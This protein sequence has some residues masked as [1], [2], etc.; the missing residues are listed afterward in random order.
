LKVNLTSYGLPKCDGSESDDSFAV[1]AWDETVIAVLA[2]GAGAARDAREA[3]RRIVQS[4][5]TNYSARPTSWS[6]QKALTEFTRIINHTLHQ[7]SL[8]RYAAP[9][10]ISTLSIAIIEGNRLFGLNV[11]DSRVYLSR[12][13][14]LSQLSHDHV[15][16]DRTFSHV[17]QRAIGL[18]PEVEPHSFET[19]LRDGD[20]AFLCSDGVS[21]VLPDD[22][23][24]RRLTHRPAARAIVQHARM[25]ATDETL[26]DM[27][28]IVIDVAETGKLR[29][30][31]QLPLPIPET[32]RR[33]E[34]ID[35][36]ELVRPFQHSDRV[37]LATKDDAHWSLKF[38]PLEARDNE[39]V[40][41]AF[42]KEQWNATRLEAPFFVKAFVPEH[43]T[44]RY[45]VMEFV[46]APSLKMLLKSRRLSVDEAI[47]LGKFLLEAST[48]LL[49]HDLVH[50]DI[51]PENI[52]VVSDYDHL[53]F[54]LVDLGSAA[55]VFS[56]ISRAGTAT[57]LA[58]ERFHGEP[59]CERT[60][61]F[62]IGVTLFH[63]L[64][65]AFPYGEIERFQT[66]QFGTPKSPARLNPNIPPW[67]ASVILRAIAV[68]PE[69]T[70]QHF[71]EFAFDLANPDKV[72]PFFQPGASLMEKNPLLFYKV[73]FWV[74]LAATLFLL[75]RLFAQ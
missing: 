11:G 66:P 2:D 62:A 56:V 49:R 25:L 37:W 29:A 70:Y 67:L 31:S 9:E 51:K 42:V 26:D 41:N 33:G 52:L 18:A 16:N 63:A 24:A 4:L 50:G 38:A 58:P 35:G 44:A 39:A 73:G 34:V 69:R 71:S 60:E 1:K 75:F 21:N 64:T 46:E 10:M 59:I 53:R 43:A 8:A 72:E 68:D 7:E 3:S 32:L 22:E 5:V 30:V 15:I 55:E 6:P 17:L 65:R 23:L 45:Y 54:K 74:L 48:H 47:A 19:E 36:Y 61:V 27:S 40:L 57:Y 12:N 14:Q 13:G 28:A 20:I